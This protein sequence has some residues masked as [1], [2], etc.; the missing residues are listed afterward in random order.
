MGRISDFFRRGRR[1]TDDVPTQQLRRPVPHAPIL[2]GN[3][4]GI[5]TREGQEDSFAL[6]NAAD[7]E[8]MTRRGVFGPGGRKSRQ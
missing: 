4:Q 2:A 5:G 1:V 7:P 3:V 8:A 6:L